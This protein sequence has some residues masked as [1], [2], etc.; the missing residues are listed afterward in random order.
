MIEIVEVLIIYIPEPTV[1]NLCFIQYT[2]NL[3]E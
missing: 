2:L 1:L 3:K